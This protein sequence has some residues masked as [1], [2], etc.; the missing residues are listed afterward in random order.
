LNETLNAGIFT[1]TIAIYC[2]K[3]FYSYQKELGGG[4]CCGEDM[5][6]IS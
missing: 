3:V 1:V 4:V 6:L 5:E 2:S